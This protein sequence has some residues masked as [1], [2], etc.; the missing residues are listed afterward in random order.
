[1]KIEKEIIILSAR[2]KFVFYL[3]LSMN[4]YL[5]EV[6]SK[7]TGID[8]EDFE[9]NLEFKNPII[10]VSSARDFQKITDILIKVNKTLIN[11]ELINCTQHN[12]EKN[13]KYLYELFFRYGFRRDKIEKI[14]QI[15]FNNNDT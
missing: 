1:M 9:N 2:Y 15:N 13:K 6:I 12:V 7:I 4:K 14:I 10:D 3:L 5:S 8:K 11:I